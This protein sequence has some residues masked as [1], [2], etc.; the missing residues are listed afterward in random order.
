[1]PEQ[2]K[3]HVGD[4]VQSKFG[5][6]QKGIIIGSSIYPGN[7]LTLYHIAYDD[8]CKYQFEKHFDYLASADDQTI[9]KATDILLHIGD[10]A[11]T[12]HYKQG[13][14]LR[15]ILGEAL[16]LDNGKDIPGSHNGI[17]QYHVLL[18]KTE[19][20]RYVDEKDIYEKLKSADD[21]SVKRAKKCLKERIIYP[22]FSDMNLP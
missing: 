18:L 11:S 7:G 4:M 21:D 19:Q 17:T 20:L 2:V 9:Q 14:T 8:R 1:M 15:T 5:K 16:V 6:K 13:D 10:A 3:F 12:S 22:A